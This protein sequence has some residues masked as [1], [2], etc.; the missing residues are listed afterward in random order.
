MERVANTLTVYVRR[1]GLT[2]WAPDVAADP[3]HAPRRVAVLAAVLAAHR[4]LPSMG[5]IIY[6]TWA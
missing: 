3:L 2:V 4:D 6:T 1:V 5:E